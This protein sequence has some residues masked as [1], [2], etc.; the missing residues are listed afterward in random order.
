MNASTWAVCCRI[1]IIPRER[2]MRLSPQMPIRNSTIFME[3]ENFMHKDNNR[4]KLIEIFEDT[5][6]LCREN[7]ELSESIKYSLPDL[8]AGVSSCADPHNGHSC[9]YYQYEKDS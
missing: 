3:N 9:K 8:S 5:M 2:L 1:W 4:E 7:D 6:R